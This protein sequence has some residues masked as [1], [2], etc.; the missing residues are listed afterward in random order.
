MKYLA[1]DSN[2]FCWRAH[3]S[4]GAM[5]F[6]GAGTGVIYGFL[7]QLYILSKTF[8]SSN[9]LFFWDSRKSHRKR[10]FPGYKDR[11]EQ[12]EEEKE[13]RLEAMRQMEVLRS[14]ILPLLGFRNIFI[15]TGLEADD[16]IARF[17][18]DN[19]QTTIVLTNDDDLL[20]LVDDCT[21]YSPS[22]KT[23]YNNKSFIKEYGIPPREWRRVKQIA[24]CT[25][26]KVP[27]V[28]GIGN[29]FALQYIKKEM[30]KDS[31]RYNNIISKESRKMIK[32]NRLLVNLPHPKT[33]GIELQ[34]EKFN[35]E[36]FLA[37]CAL[38]GLNKLE[39][40]AGDWENLFRRF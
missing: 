37:V 2:Y 33:K 1:F 3:H 4:T 15:Q 18:R 23:S 17:V 38:Y 7:S 19:P 14:E 30:K 11:G 35:L 26:D 28:E 21:M 13:D 39:E 20:Q 16:L 32:R 10:T 6:A 5:S 9:P 34:K 36:G 31:K 22:R 29:V 24:G 12:T 27:G 25:S 8:D 40:Q